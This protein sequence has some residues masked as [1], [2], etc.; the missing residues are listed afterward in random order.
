MVRHAHTLYNQ[1][2]S[3]SPNR[4]TLLDV[5]VRKAF[6]KYTVPTEGFVQPPIIFPL[7]FASLLFDCKSYM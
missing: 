1:E 7:R 6:A 4:V 5:H 2:I 3:P